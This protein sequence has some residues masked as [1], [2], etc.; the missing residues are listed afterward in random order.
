VPRATKPSP[1]RLGTKGR[2]GWILVGVDQRWGH[3][4]IF[5]FIFIII[6]IIFII[7]IIIVIIII[8]TI[9]IIIIV[10]VIVIF[11]IFIIIFIIFII[12]M[13]MT[14]TIT[15]I[16]SYCQYWISHVEAEPSSFSAAP[17][18]G[19]FFCPRPCDTGRFGAEAGK[20]DASLCHLAEWLMG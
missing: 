6:S 12:I 2:L 16:E 20:T 19:I 8:I 1:A 14:I 15:T 17:G 7:I 4:F 5:I 9:I 13:I 11:I 10:I 3:I 18:Y